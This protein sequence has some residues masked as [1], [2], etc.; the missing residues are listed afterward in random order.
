MEA[1]RVATLRGHQVTLYEKE[2]KLGGQLILAA[3]PPYKKDIRDLTAYMINQLRKLKVKVVLGK[4]ITPGEIKK[5]KPDVVILAAGVKPLIPSPEDIPGLDT[6]KNVVTA[7]DVLLGKAKV[8][9]KVFIIGGD[10]VGC[11]TAEF[12]ADQ[13]KQ[14]TIARRSQFM[15][16]KMNPD[17]RMLLV[18]RM[19]NKGIRML[20]GVQYQQATDTGIR[21]HMRGGITS[22]AEIAADAMKNFP[23]DTF[24]LA[25]GSVPNN[26]LK[27]AIEKTGVKVKCV[28]DCV[29][30]RTIL[31]AIKEGWLA[32]SEI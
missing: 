1:A 20:T 32:A 30:A 11:E 23:A 31:E 3:I 5:A 17:M 8:G 27:A 19:R 14:V 13:G 18:D 10:L 29:E 12:L 26:E 4:A 7:E 2:R 28:G 16:N 25:A 24:V 15:A 6:L 21:V 9:N 22:M